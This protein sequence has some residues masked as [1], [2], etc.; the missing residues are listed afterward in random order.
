MP[1]R[2]A[3]P[4][5]AWLRAHPGVEVIC[6]DRGA[7]AYAEGAALGVPDALQVADVDGSAPASSR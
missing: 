4:L 5:V 3:A 7:V 2:E 1:S 6:R